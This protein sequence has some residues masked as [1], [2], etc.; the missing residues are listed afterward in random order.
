MGTKDLGYAGN[1]PNKWVG[2][3]CRCIETIRHGKFGGVSTGQF[4]YQRNQILDD[5][6]S[7][8]QGALFLLVPIQNCAALK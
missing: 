3:T 5:T 1:A 2:R 6:K 7:V 4:I 8:Q